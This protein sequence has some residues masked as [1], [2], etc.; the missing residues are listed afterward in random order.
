M[1][2]ILITGVNSYVGNNLEKWLAKN[3]ENY[4]VDKLSLKNSSWEKGNFS[5]YEVVVHVAG[6]AHVSSDPKK[7][8]E[9]YRVNRDLTIKV[10]EK[11]KNE[12][13]KQ[14]IFLS[15]IIVYGDVSGVIN[16]DTIP[17][18]RD[19]YGESKLQA[20]QGIMPLN[21]SKFKVATIRPPMI[22]G[23]DSKGNYPKLSMV[24][25]KI[26]IFP[27]VENKRSMLHIDNLCEFIRLIIDNEESGLLFPQNEEYVQTSEM[28]RLIAESYGKKIKLVRWFNP[29]ILPLRNKI[30]ILNKVFGDL[31]YDKEMSKYSFDY[32][33]R[34]MEESIKFTE[35]G[36]QQ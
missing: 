17:N 3:T 28:V 20:E 22:Y 27:W 14:F 15:S 35:G 7:K 33:V 24:A 36:K 12:G 19:Y 10:A 9:Y 29:A 26:P 13:V 34:N 4:T 18:P 6:I 2:K 16:K 8:E 25:Q 1:R 5:K 32:R 30:G 23:R 21:E 31:F 11:A